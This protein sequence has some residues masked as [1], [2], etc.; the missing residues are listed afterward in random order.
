M[1]GNHSR[2]KGHNFEREIAKDLRDIWPNARRGFQCRDGN[3][4]PDVET[5]D[6]FW[7]ECKCYKKAPIRRALEQARLCAG[8]RRWAVAITKDDGEKPIVTMSYEDWKDMVKVLTE[9]QRMG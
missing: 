6:Q 3:E 2:R 7:I 5:D 9:L 4:Q 8:R 1:S